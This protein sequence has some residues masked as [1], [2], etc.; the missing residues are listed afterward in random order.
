MFLSKKKKNPFEVRKKK[1]SSFKGFL[2][3]KYVIIS[4]SSIGFLI[5]FCGALFLI[6]KTPATIAYNEGIKGKDAFLKAQ[7]YLIE[8]NFTA[9]KESLN[10]A[11]QNFHNASTEFDKFYWL[12]V[13]PWIGPQVSA[14]SNMLLAGIATGDSIIKITDVA[15]DIISPLQKDS[16][17]SLNAL[18]EEETRA[19]LEGIYNAKHVL[20]DAQYLIDIAVE[21]LNEIP[22]KGLINKIR[23]VV[24]PLKEKVP[25]IQLA[26]EKATSASQIIPWIAGYP[27]ERV[28]LFL[29]QNNTELRPAGGFIGTYGI[30]KVINGDIDSFWTENSYNL[31]EPAEA[32]LDEEPPWPLTRYNAVQ[33]WLFRDSNWSPDFPTSAQKAEW[34]YHAEKGSE[35]NISGI[36]AVTPTFIQSLIKLTGEISVNGITFTQDNLVEKLQYE[37]EKGY[38]RQGIELSERK[39]IIG[40]LSKKILDGILDLP[41]SK[42]A[43][44]WEV[45][46]QDV[47]EKHI[48]IY[49]NDEYVQ[50]LILKENWGGE[51]QSAEHDYLMVVDANLASLKSDPVVKRDIKYRL[52]QDGENLIADVEITYNH[53]GEITWKTT[54]YRTYTR[55]YVP[56]GSTLLSSS[57]SMVDCKMND[58]GSVEQGDE[59]GK[60][61]FGTFICIEPGEVKSLKFKYKLP[62]DVSENILSQNYS[63]LVQKQS[64]TAAYPL[65]ILI[66]LDKKIRNVV[67]VDST[68]I[69]FN[70][71]L[72]VSTV[73]SEDRNITTYY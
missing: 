15:I 14:V 33:Q 19:L 24:A 59:L 12:R 11:S 44:L 13:L 45:F 53:I 55:V 8:Q 7:D 5:I 51:V 57:G 2:K 72:S 30:L 66:E 23:D 27:D 73:L 9:A 10:A 43:D 22:Q 60:T 39:E 71:G 25:E 34:F 28:Y 3:K 42:W 58:E 48:L 35:S 16:E 38:L 1:N 26:I 41:K 21:H 4:V 70:N 36:I 52:R 62:N 20:E 63:L 46:S 32:W 31:D 40:V 17:L 56:Q 29:L 67:G 61:T 6:Y 68:D 64:G 37:V 49:V 54:R 69:L 47:T 18:S 65:N 50:N